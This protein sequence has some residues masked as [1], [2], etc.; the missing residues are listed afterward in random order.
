MVFYLFVISNVFGSFISQKGKSLLRVAKLIE[1]MIEI[2]D[3]SRCWKSGYA[4][5]VKA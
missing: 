5:K 2:S 3:N 1:V 4:P